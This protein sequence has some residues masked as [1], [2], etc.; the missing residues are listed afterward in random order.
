MSPL[1]NKNI[2]VYVSS[3]IR[4]NMSSYINNFILMK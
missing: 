3:H 4:E 2:T 1:V